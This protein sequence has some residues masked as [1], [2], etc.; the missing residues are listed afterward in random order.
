MA[1]AHLS[2]DTRVNDTFRS[3]S[4]IVPVYNRAELV[5]VCLRHLRQAAQPLIGR[6]I[7][8]EIIVADDASTD[9]SGETVAALADKSGDVSIRLVSLPS[10]VGPGRARNAALDAAHGELIVFV[11]SDIIVIPGFLEAHLAAYSDVR[12][13]YTVGTVVSVPDVDTALQYPSPTKWD[14]SNASLHTA[15][16]SVPRAVLEQ[17]GPFDTGFEGYGWEDLDLGRRLKKAGLKRVMVQEAIGYHVDP[18]LATRERFLTQLEKERQRG[19]NAVRFLHK[20]PEFSAR[21][22]AQDTALHRGL[23]WLFRFGGLVREDNV[24]DWVQWARR[25]R[26]TAL[27]R[28]WMAGVLN[29]VYLESLA[30]AKRAH[31]SN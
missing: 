18:P 7:H 23:N 25:H 31:S 3:M 4:V 14:L 9:G 24:L 19:R 20:H 21:L 22:T 1:L 8:V 17:V 13:M 27:E 12:S 10:R 28:M 15:N 29:Q 2:N 6:G 11:D 16:A 26:L 5:E 30:Q